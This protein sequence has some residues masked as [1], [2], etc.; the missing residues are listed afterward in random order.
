MTKRILCLRKGDIID[1]KKGWLK[2]TGYKDPYFKVDVLEPYDGD[3]NVKKTGAKMYTRET[4]M[5]QAIEN[6]HHVMYC[7]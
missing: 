2:V 1:T 6:V 5:K 3:G 4:I 7:Q